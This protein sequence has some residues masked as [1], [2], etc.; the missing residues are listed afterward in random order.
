[1]ADRSDFTELRDPA[2]FDMQ[3]EQFYAYQNQQFSLCRYGRDSTNTVSK[4]TGN[5]EAIVKQMLGTL[6]H[7]MG[8][9]RK[10]Q[11]CHHAELPGILW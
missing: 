4:A 11:A 2:Y 10:F 6:S 3:T 8:S 5:S 1:M 9:P 7:G